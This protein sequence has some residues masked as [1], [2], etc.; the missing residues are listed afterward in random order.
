MRV[1]GVALMS[2]RRRAQRIPPQSPPRRKGEPKTSATRFI[3]WPN[4]HETLTLG[5]L[6]GPPVPPDDVV[7]AAAA[8]G[9]GARSTM[10]L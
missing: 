10:V 3:R 7:V 8:F 6:P 9:D 2:A 1:G 5:M 4:A